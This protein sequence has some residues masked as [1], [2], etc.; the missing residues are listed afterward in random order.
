MSRS[1][2]QIQLSKELNMVSDY[3]VW[4]SS[5][6]E[7][8]I[9][10]KKVQKLVY[11]AQAWNL[12]FSGGTNLFSDQ[13]EAWMHGPAIRNLWHKYKKYGYQPISDIPQEVSISSETKTLLDEIWRVYGKYDA[14][15]L[16]ALTHSEDPWL[17]AREGLDVD[18]TSSIVITNDSMQRYYTALNA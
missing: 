11:Y 15:Y 8:P 1:F 14:S 12:V 17:K 18:E 10:N 9:T 2:S 13:I 7:K 6:S 4:K 16:E 3:F 5:Q